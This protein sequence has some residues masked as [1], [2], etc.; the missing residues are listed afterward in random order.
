MTP[1][2][3]TQLNHHLTE[4]ARI[5]KQNTPQSQLT[6]FECVELTVRQHLLETVGPA[7]GEFFS[8]EEPKSPSEND[9]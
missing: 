7:I 9:R 4:A 2:E 5:L 1:E 6:D 8:P 3:A